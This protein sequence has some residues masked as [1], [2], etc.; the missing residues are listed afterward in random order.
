MS[1]FPRSSSL[2]PA[3]DYVASFHRRRFR[4]YVLGGSTAYGE[5]YGPIAD[6]GRV[7]SYLFDTR[8]RGEEIRVVNRGRP[9]WASADV[10]RDLD[11]VTRV[12]PKGGALAPLYLGNNEFLPY[13]VPKDPAMSGRPLFDSPTID[14]GTR[15]RVLDSY[16]D[17]IAGIVSKLKAAKIPAIASTTPVNLSDWEPNRSVLKDPANAESVKASLSDGDHEMQALRFRSALQSYLRIVDSEPGFAVASKKIGDCY[18]RLGEIDLARAFYQKA[19]DD[20]GNPYRETSHQDTILREVCATHGVPVIEAVKVLT[21]ASRDRLIG[22]EYMWDNCHPTF[23]G[24]LRI[25]E[26]F[27]EEMESLFDTER[28][29]AHP[30][31]SEIADAL[32]IDSAVKANVLISRGQYCYRAATLIHDPAARLARSR[33]YLD[34]AASFDP[35]NVELVCS[36]AV[37]AALC[38]DVRT[39]LSH[40]RRAYRLDPASSRS[41]ISHPIVAGI[42][43][44]NGV[45]DVNNALGD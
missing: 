2:A 42:M 12:R 13:D 31:A 28:A 9:G 4:L 23:E 36:Y 8:I 33:Y 21:E 16:K 25:A 1:R 37:L 11:E 35:D 19:V 22:Y 7:L 32:G 20:D 5:P 41:R 15:Q 27:A 43:Q 34:Q 39:S 26:A 29:R 38:G 18:R 45:S 24:Y 17:S 30:A 3:L 44:W 10:L 6:L 14:A 40:W